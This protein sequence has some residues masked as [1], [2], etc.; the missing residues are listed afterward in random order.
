[1]NLVNPFDADPGTSVLLVRA[2]LHFLWQGALLAAAVW[3]AEPA[4]ARLSAAM[5]Y[6]VLLAALATIAACPFVTLWVG[7]RGGPAD[8]G[9]RYG[10]SATG[11][12]VVRSGV[13]PV[14]AWATGAAPAHMVGA[15][16]AA[17]A[18][19]YR[20]PAL[21]ERVAPWATRAYVLGVALMLVRLGLAARVARSLF[22]DAVEAD[23]GLRGRCARLATRLG[24]RAAPPVRYCVRIATPA[25]VGL[26]RPI[27]LLP[28]SVASELSAAQLEAILAH[29]LAHVRRLDPLANLFQR[30]VESFLFFHPAVWYV[31][32]RVRAER[33]NCCDDV[34]LGLGGAGA[35]EYA[36]ALVKIA[37]SAR[38]RATQ[39]MA[40]AAVGPRSRLGRRIVRILGD[41]QVASIGP[42]GV[43]L[44]AALLVA[45]AV[46][47]VSAQ[48]TTDR[49]AGSK[50][51]ATITAGV[52]PATRALRTV[53]LS[54][55]DAGREIQLQAHDRV[56]VA[57]DAGPE[58]SRWIVR[59]GD[60]VNA[61]SFDERRIFGRDGRLSRQEFVFDVRDLKGGEVVLELQDVSADRASEA[62]PAQEFEAEAKRQ[63]ERLRAGAPRNAAT[64]E[65]LFPEALEAEVARMREHL[66][67]W[68]GT[69][70]A[71]RQAAP[72]TKVTRTLVFQ[73]RAG[74]PDAT[75]L[76][77]EWL[78]GKVKSDGTVTPGD[79]GFKADFAV[80]SLAGLAFL[81][82]ESGPGEGPYGAKVSAI[83][84]GLLA[85]QQASGLLAAG[86]GGMY[87]HGYATLFLAEAYMK[88]RDDRVAGAL[89]RAVAVIEGAANAEGGWRY[90]P[91]PL[92][93]DVS[94]T[95]C[96]LNAL[97]AA[98]AAGIAVRG[99]VIDRG[100]AYVRRCENAD[101]GFSYMAG[102]AGFGGSGW[103]RS[104]A[105]VAVLIH[106]GAKLAD[107]DVVKG[108]RFAS[109]RSAWQVGKTHWEYAMYY[110]S[111]W[112]GSAARDVEGAGAAAQQVSREQRDDGSWKG[113]VS[114]AYATASAL[115]VLQAR[116]QRLWIFR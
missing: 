111:Q 52:G 4:L 77:L 57:L 41:E 17:A 48:R 6:R 100:L 19:T 93:A 11:E 10:P 53:V 32:S 96:E 103:P 74:R 86:D 51:N 3:A 14:D 28:A 56:T 64:G 87:E 99:E 102:Q 63:E 27:V 92:D 69:G 13:Q 55:A 107:E 49:P 9:A 106:G 104:A 105:A 70:A 91:R 5:R 16:G 31:S 97:L 61:K 33:E 38:W 80:P 15:I 26:V 44:V 115:I 90:S 88:R 113:D 21:L 116:G 37:D 42:R 47:V 84:D 75:R 30:L 112:I 29:E 20:P 65:A 68:P 98:R 114:D 67:E 43:V 95:A 40:L 23:S 25:V 1:M 82:S 66:K 22:R 109:D 12:V 79:K 59:G 94:V 62:W 78:A 54:E 71:G 76:G 58:N 108:I 60:E 81:A 45:V 50:A 7:T 34:V 24:M 83:V 39:S 101:G 89:R 73:L 36:D 2:A 110:T 35:A 72:P 46:A 8:S 18:E 85:R